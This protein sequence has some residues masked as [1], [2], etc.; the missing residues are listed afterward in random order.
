[1][2]LSTYIL[3]QYPPLAFP[4]NFDTLTS[5]VSALSPFTPFE[6]VLMARYV[7]EGYIYKF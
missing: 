6:I 5:R 2:V 1:M 3:P 7:L 4:V